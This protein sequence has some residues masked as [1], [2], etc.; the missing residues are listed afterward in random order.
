MAVTCTNVCMYLCSI[1]VVSMYILS[2]YLCIYVSMYLCMYTCSWPPLARP[3][4]C[5][6][7]TL[8]FDILCSPAWP[9]CKPGP[10]LKNLQSFD[11]L[12]NCTLVHLYV[13]YVYLPILSVSI[14][15]HM[16]LPYL[17][18]F[19]Q[20]TLSILSNLILP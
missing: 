4:W 17:I 3:S 15:L 12:E 10:Q 20:L 6:P 2:M 8:R 7:D 14:F 18:D 5:G 16:I 1:Y 19:L 11:G 9:T 13:T